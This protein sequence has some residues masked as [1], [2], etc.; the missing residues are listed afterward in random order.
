MRV[1]YDNTEKLQS[2]IVGIF[3]DFYQ[4]DTFDPLDLRIRTKTCRLKVIREK[5]R[6]MR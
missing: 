4:V 1:L 3:Y 6:E 2:L 5:V